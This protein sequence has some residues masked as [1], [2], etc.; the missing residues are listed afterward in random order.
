MCLSLCTQVYKSQTYWEDTTAER[1]A[2]TLVQLTN[3]HRGHHSYTTRD[4]SPSDKA[5]GVNYLR[6][7]EAAAEKMDRARVTKYMTNEMH[8]YGSWCGGGGTIV[9]ITQDAAGPEF[10][11][12]QIY[13]DTAW[14]VALA[15]MGYEVAHQSEAAPRANLGI[16]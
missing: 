4:E 7:A 9:E 12:H 2:G 14:E 3:V 15:D 13:Y 5:A 11:G 10:R 16:G 8:E 1:A 6:R